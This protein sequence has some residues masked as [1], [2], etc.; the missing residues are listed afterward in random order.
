M[1]DVV[2]MDQLINPWDFMRYLDNDMIH[3][4]DDGYKLLGHNLYLYIED[5][6][7]KF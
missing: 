7:D 3:L 1:Y 4:N 6:Y 5:N 2:F